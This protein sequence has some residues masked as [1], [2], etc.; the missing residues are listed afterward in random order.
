MDRYCRICMNDM[1]DEISI[2]QWFLQE[3]YICKNCEDI[4]IPCKKY[5]NL[6][7][8]RLYVA[9]YYTKELEEI[10]FQWKEDRDIALSEVFLHRYKKWMKKKFKNYTLVYVPSSMDKIKARGFYSL[11]QMYKEIQLPKVHL[12]LK[13][14]GYKQSKQSYSMRQYVKNYIYRNNEKIPQT[15]ICLIDDVCTSGSTL[16]ACYESL[17]AEGVLKK[18][19]VAFVFSATK[20]FI[21]ENRIRSKKIIKR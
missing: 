11:V 14:N 19:V 13:A 15:P 8:L 10:L 9:Y 4:F 17:I 18:D 20:S 6:N 5:I 2:I 7:G 12:F 1:L 16:L 21:N 3:S